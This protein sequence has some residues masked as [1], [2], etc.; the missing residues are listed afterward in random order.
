MGAQSG[1]KVCRYEQL[2]R[3]PE[4]KTALAYEAIFNCPVSE[5]FPD[6]FEKIKTAVQAR[7]KTL[8][9][10]AL[11]ASSTALMAQKR[12]AVAGIITKK[13]IHEKK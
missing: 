8:A 1:S 6:L 10:R 4:L 11:L 9:K 3:V 13:R 2:D 7:A 5:L 12:K